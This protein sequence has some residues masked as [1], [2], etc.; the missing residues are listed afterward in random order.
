[1]GASTLLAVS[2]STVVYDT[3]SRVTV[4]VVCNKT[5]PSHGFSQFTLVPEL[6]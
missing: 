5:G 2:S 1:V 6:L 4:S 3:Q